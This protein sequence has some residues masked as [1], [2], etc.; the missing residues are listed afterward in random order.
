VSP[1][2]LLQNLTRHWVEDPDSDVV[3]TGEHEGRWGLRM[4]QR[5]R[6]FTTVWFDV[7]QITIGFEAYL[8]PPPRY[9]TAEVLGY[10][11]KRNYRSWPAFIAADDRG[12]LYVRGRVPI[13]GLTEEDIETALG[14]IYELIEISFQPLLKLG[15]I[16]EVE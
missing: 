6:D 2:E 10:C 12:E 1:L 9:N 8:L 4:A 5:A 13:A 7:G 16:S 11:L 14:T 3:W 15:Y